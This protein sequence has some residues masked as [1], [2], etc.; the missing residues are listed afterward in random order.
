VT[1]KY[2]DWQWHVMHT[3]TEAQFNAT[4]GYPSALT[5][6]VEGA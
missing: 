3:M 2:P 4:N 6:L 1:A 5:N